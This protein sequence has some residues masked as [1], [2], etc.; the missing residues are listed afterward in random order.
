MRFLDEFSFEF[1]G[2]ERNGVEQENPS[3]LTLEA[4]QAYAE[5]HGCDA[6]A[7]LGYTDACM[8]CA[9]SGSVSYTHLLH[10]VD[11]RRGHCGRA[12]FIV[13]ST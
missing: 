10:S 2:C 7:G 13:Y 5:D 1:T 3:Q 8:N 11:E 12:V 9:G 4:L 6:C